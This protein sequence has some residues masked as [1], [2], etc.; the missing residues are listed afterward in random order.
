VEIF[1]DVTP[2]YAESGGQIGDT[3][4]IETDSSRARVIDTTSA[5]P[6]LTRHVAVIEEGEIRA[7][8]VATASIDTERRAAIR[9]NH[10]GTHLVHWALRE[11]LGEHVKQ[12]GSL[13]A[14]DYLRFDFTHYEPLSADETSRVEDLVNREILT[15]ED[16]SIEIMGKD[17][18]EQAGAIAFFEEKYGD[19]V[20]V[21]QAGNESLELCGGTHVAR[22]GQ[23]GP[24]E[25]VS[26]GSIG[27]N[28]R[29]IFATTGTT[30]LAR[31]RRVERQLADTATLLRSTP[32]EVPAAVERKL[33][34]LR[35]VEGRL[36]QAEQAA[37]GARAKTLVD[38]SVD[39]WLVARVDGLVANQLQELANQVR[40]AGALH[41]VVLGGSPDGSRV[42]LVALAA[43][44]QPVTAPELIGPAARAV[45]GGGG[46]KDP[47]RATAGGRDPGRLDEAL[48]QIRSVLAR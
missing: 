9:R 42:A 18:A 33:A 12:Q 44:G 24:F 11:V 26:E 30:T 32:D 47:E 37:L 27:S 7:G 23:I 46:G 36:R 10:T 39:G 45:G 28:L 2:F 34:D 5:L 38:Q 48:D 13:V 31:L 4:L 40:Q 3:G 25:I 8:Q 1:L 21:V 43:K 16:V 6:G 15:D 19:E 41:T 22:L 20:R 29:R 17:E 14:P 35:E